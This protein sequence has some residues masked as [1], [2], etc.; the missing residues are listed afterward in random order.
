LSPH[1]QS[2]LDALVN[3]SSRQAIASSLFVSVNTVKTQLAAVYQKLGSSTREEAL[4][5]ARDHELLPPA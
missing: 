2:V 4:R 3:T 1:E 5:K